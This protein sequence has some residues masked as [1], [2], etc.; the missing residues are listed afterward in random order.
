MNCIYCSKTLEDNKL[1]EHLIPKSLYQ[2]IKA[3][4]PTNIDFYIRV[5]SCIECNNKKSAL[6]EKF[7]NIITS[8]TA[9]LSPYSAE[10]IPSV[11]RSLDKNRKF[12]ELFSDAN[13][14]KS[15]SGLIKFKDIGFDSFNYLKLIARGI[16]WLHTDKILE[17][18]RLIHVQQF[19]PKKNLKF[20][21]SSTW[22]KENNFMTKSHQ[23]DTVFQYLWKEEFRGYTIFLSFF[24]YGNFLCVIPNENTGE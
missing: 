9:H 24:E 1:R 6:D 19:D 2:S 15:T 10:L 22:I 14:T 21:P 18:N 7:K 17:G 12:Q 8:S 5:P 13:F 11:K 20:I 23:L 4:S 16:Y 3:S